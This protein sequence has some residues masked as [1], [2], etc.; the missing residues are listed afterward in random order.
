MFID[1]LKNVLEELLSSPILYGSSQLVVSYKHCIFLTLVKGCSHAIHILSL[2]KT[3]FVSSDGICQDSLHKALFK[4][5]TG[6]SI[7]YL[8]PKMFVRLKSLL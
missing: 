3:I 7:W 1:C 5:H 6:P 4:K 8:Q 2:K